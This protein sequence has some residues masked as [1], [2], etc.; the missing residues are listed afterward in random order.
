MRWWRR[1]E[2]CVYRS[3][4][5]A[6]WLKLPRILVLATLPGWGKRTFM[7]QC[8]DFLRQQQPATRVVW[9]TAV[10]DLGEDADQARHKGAD[11][12]LLCVDARYSSDSFWHEMDVMLRARPWASVIVGC[13]DPPPD[14]D[15][16]DA[17]ASADPPV[18]A[19]EKLG[20]VVLHEDD[21][22]FDAAELSEIIELLKESG[23][24]VDALT[25][26]QE[27]GCPALVGRQI[28]RLLA[29]GLQG[30]WMQANPSIETEVFELIDGGI[31][32]DAFGRSRIGR[33]IR[34]ACELPAFNAELIQHAAGGKKEA[35]TVLSRLAAM[36]LFGVDDDETGSRQCTWT[37]AAWRYLQ[38]YEQPEQTRARLEKGLERVR[39]AGL[40]VPQLRLRLE[41]G[42]LMDAEKLVAETYRRI[43]LLC[44]SRTVAILS[45]DQR[46]EPSELPMLTMLRN[47][48]L[49]RTTGF[50][51][52]L[53][54]ENRE[55]LLRLRRSSARG[56][57]G[58]VARSSRIAYAASYAGSRD[59][60]LRYLSYLRELL[61][62]AGEFARPDLDAIDRQTV[63][64][65]CFLGYWSAL[66]LDRV[67][68]ALVMAE[69]MRVWGD[70]AD[71]L[72]PTEVVCIQSVQDQAG[73]R[74]LGT[75]GAAPACDPLNVAEAFIAIEDG[76]DDKAMRA[77]ETL[78]A[79]LGT[80]NSRS[81]SDGLALLTLAIASGGST[82]VRV[83][84]SALRDSAEHWDDQV[85]S[86]FLTWAGI[87]ALSSIGAKN[88]ARTWLARLAG[89][90][91][92]FTVLARMT[93]ALWDGTPQVGLD[94]LPLAGGIELPRMLVCTKV[95]A[96]A[97][98]AQLGDAD[99]ARL[100][101]EQA[102]SL[103]PAPRLFRFGFRLIP[104]AMFDELRAL[105]RPSHD[106]LVS[107]F[108]ASASDK[109][110][111]T[112]QT[113]PRITPSEHEILQMLARGMSNAAI[114][115]AR[116]I[117]VGTLRTHLKSLY[118]KLGVSDR[119][120]ALRAAVRFELIKV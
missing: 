84:E 30:A 60:A 90:H 32:G 63:L 25:T 1:D 73:L 28:E 24:V 117:T 70:A 68:D 37:P 98:Y 3:H 89:G 72:H 75:D 101:L 108:E 58:E 15:S 107:V 102:W 118:K 111:L 105:T 69:G 96:A 112:W 86:T 83:A 110:N 7:L 67:E 71:R 103:H 9:T 12:V 20:R 45:G 62:S 57:Y 16:D 49:L 65:A 119:S 109:R 13:Y 36:P 50:S 81:A 94:A 41:L 78:V 85:P 21:L 120:E 100:S 116:F 34:D 11:A 35:K 114:A 91:D 115:E 64:D 54:A 31:V 59:V 5:E 97:A 77:V 4:F 33:V 66:Q 99:R 106:A 52:K 79:D 2:R 19:D 8:A 93:F 10:S 51:E 47:Q 14:V 95:L 46:I 27:R 38:R 92:V 74:S 113:R 44:D 48:Y 42:D 26:G 39:S 82:T 55:V 43:L 76:R 80:H 17:L 104:Q 61:R 40:L 87:T 23:A 53:R 29:R 56:R 88:E 18:P 6:L 22:A